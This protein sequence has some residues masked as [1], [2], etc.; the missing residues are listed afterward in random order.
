MEL[1]RFQLRT[2]ADLN[3]AMEDRGRR[4]IILKSP[5]GSGKTIVLT[6]FMSEYMRGHAHTVFV[7]LTPG[8]GNLEEQS[9]A[10]M[11]RYCHGA[12]TKLLSDVM[13]GGFEAGDAVFIN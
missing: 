7:W 4:D 9:K 11:D 10:K 6:H 5:T 13:T 1:K 8:E 12:A 2:I 3:A